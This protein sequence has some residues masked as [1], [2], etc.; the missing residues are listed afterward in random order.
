MNQLQIANVA[1]TQQLAVHN[2]VPSREKSPGEIKNERAE[3]N[4]R[5][6]EYDGDYKS[7][8]QYVSNLAD[9]MWKDNLGYV[10]TNLEK[11]LKAYTDFQDQIKREEEEQLESIINT[12]L[13]EYKGKVIILKKQLKG[14]SERFIKS[15]IENAIDEYETSLLFKPEVEE[16]PNE[17]YILEKNHPMTAPL[18]VKVGMVQIDD[19]CTPNILVEEVSTPKE[20]T[21]SVVLRGLTRQ[22]IALLNKSHNIQRG[23]ITEE[24]T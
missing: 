1:K 18:S 22:E 9:A 15:Y 13:G 8:K 12:H 14:K 11:D 10:K 21:Y 24:R 3:I 19:S 16:E 23:D 6:R 2:L 4:K 7:Y 5:L 20:K 17:S